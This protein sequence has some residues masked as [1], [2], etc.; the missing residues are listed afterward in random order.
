MKLSKVVFFDY[1]SSSEATEACDI[2]LL[3]DSL[4][5]VAVESR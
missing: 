3:Q 2:R 4:V 5:I 1:I